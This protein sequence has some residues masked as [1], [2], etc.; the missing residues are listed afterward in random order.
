MFHGARPP[1]NLAP[2]VREEEEEE[3]RGGAGAQDPVVHARPTSKGC[4]GCVC[5][6]GLWGQR[7]PGGGWGLRSPG[8]GPAPW[9]GEGAAFW[10]V[11]FICAARQSTQQFAAR[12]AWKK[13]FSVEVNGPAQINGSVWVSL[14]VKKAPES[15]L[16]ALTWHSRIPACSPLPVAPQSLP[17]L[18]QLLLTAPGLSLS[19]KIGSPEKPS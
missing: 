18:I 8:R 15:P 9:R 3:V 1:W 2:A 17:A 7:K 10:R 14:H 13:P 6:S 16:G 19:T 12:H 11:S 4:G 5:P